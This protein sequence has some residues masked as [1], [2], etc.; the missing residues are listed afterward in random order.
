M[1]LLSIAAGPR[2]AA[3]ACILAAPI[4]VS[5]PPASAQEPCETVA[6]ELA[7]HVVCRFDLR[8]Y[9][10]RLFLNGPDGNPLGRL[11]RLREL[12]EGSRLVFAMNAGMF[13][14]N[15][16]PVGLYVEKG[17]T[18][19]D[20]N[21]EDGTGNFHLKPNGIFFV[22]DGSAGVLETSA[23]LAL[24]RRVEFATQ[25][26]P[27]LV[28]NGAIHPKFS[29]DGPSRKIRN[30]VGIQDEHIVVFA[31]SSE[32]VSFGHFARL[33]RDHLACSNALYLDG[34]TS[35]LFAPSLGRDDA[36]GELGPIV[37]ALPRE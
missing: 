18:L 1:N 31:I 30:G 3:V 2:A 34:E 21:V 33:F 26:G 28:I 20:V 22:N 32:P 19:K 8:S 27:M 15:L 4:G 6:F 29:I 5:A 17:E 37:G 24:G 16:S 9:E 23:F 25:S 7:E 35:S 12:P 11:Q 14:E 36:S 13:H 10:I